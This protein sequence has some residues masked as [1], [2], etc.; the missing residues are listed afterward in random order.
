MALGVA[1]LSITA[2][3][4]WDDKSCPVRVLKSSKATSK[5]G[6]AFEGFE[7]AAA[8][9][10]DG[11]DM[12]I[13]VVEWKGVRSWGQADIINSSRPPALVLSPVFLTKVLITSNLRLMMSMTRHPACACFST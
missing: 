2:A 11:V 10:E 12:L 3:K 6:L 7:A 5:F 9:E 8:E 1:Q 13:I 4:E